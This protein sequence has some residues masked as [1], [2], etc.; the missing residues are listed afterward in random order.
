MMNKHSEL[1]K[2]IDNKNMGKYYR[3]KY[4]KEKDYEKDI[5]GK[6]QRWEWREN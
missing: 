2:F 6:I 4:H 5:I 3:E 1:I